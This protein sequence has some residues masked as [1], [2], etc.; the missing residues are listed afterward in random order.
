MKIYKSEQTV[1]LGIDQV[2][3]RTQIFLVA[4][5]IVVVDINDDQ[6]AFVISGNPGFV[7]LIQALQVIEPDAFFVVAAAFLDVVYQGR[8]ACAQ[9]NKKIRG[10]NERLNKVK[11]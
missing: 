4:R 3:D 2:D 7:A 9:L 11:E 1:D 10:G 5:E 6:L 8:Y